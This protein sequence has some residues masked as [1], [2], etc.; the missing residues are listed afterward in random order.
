MSV[1]ADAKVKPNLKVYYS[2][3]YWTN[4]VGIGDTGAKLCGMSIITKAHDQ[5]VH[6]KYYPSTNIYWV[7]LFKDSWRIPNGTELAIEVGFDNESWGS[8]DHAIGNTLDHSGEIEFPIGEESVGS[9]LE[10]VAGAKVM[11]IKF[12][13]GNEKPW[14]TPMEGS[15]NS[16]TSFAKCA[17]AVAGSQTQPFS[18]NTQPYSNGSQPFSKNKNVP[19]SGNSV[20][21]TINCNEL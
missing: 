12:P 16:V 9:F 19:T 11:W 7:Q 18:N 14:T 8:M 17:A 21:S 15:R 5:A 10:N 2:S 3:G 1:H 4:Y 20:C 6:I 13:D